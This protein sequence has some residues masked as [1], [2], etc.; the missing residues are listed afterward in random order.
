V[1]AANEEYYLGMPKVKKVTYKILPDDVNDEQ[2]VELFNK[3]E[4]DVVRLADK[5]TAKSIQGDYQI[6][7]L[8]DPFITF[9]WLDT[10]RDKSPYV[11]KTPN[12]LKNK[13]VRQ[14]IYKTI[15]VNNP[16]KQASLSA[17]P[18]SQLVTNAIFGY[19]PAITRPEQNIEE[20]KK[21]M[22]QAG[23][24]D[25]FSLTLD[26]SS[27]ETQEKEG[28]AI[29]EE[30]K[31][32]NIKVK[33]T[34]VSD[35]QVFDKLIIEKDT[36]A[37]VIDYGAE[38]FDSGEIFTVLLR[39]QEDPKG[40]DNI[41]NYSNPEIDKLADEIS[42]TFDPINRQKKLQGAMVKAME[43]VPM[44]PLYNREVFYIVRD[45]FDWTPSAFGAI[46]GAEVSG[47]QVVTE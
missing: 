39:T 37:F 31:K 24:G 32:I 7:S 12:P 3:G 11:D 47:R 1:L 15:N 14:A 35:E 43:E 6:K 8:A 22:I 38:T 5:E 4:I 28:N 30:L 36:S 2:I 34:E 21:L 26:I 23:V 41:T 9:L 29:A 45:N 46:Y 40:T 33:L 27:G 20:A 16:I 13:L 18:A 19:N 25:G 17:I 42:T 44:L 10:A